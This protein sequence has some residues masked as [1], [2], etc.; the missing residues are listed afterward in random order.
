MYEVGG[1]KLQ[2]QVDLSGHAR[3]RRSPLSRTPSIFKLS[4]SLVYREPKFVHNLDEFM[5]RVVYTPYNWQ[6]GKL[7]IKLPRNSAC[8]IKRCSYNHFSYM[9]SKPLGILCRP[10]IY[11]RESP[12][13]TLNIPI[14]IGHS[15]FVEPRLI[16]SHPNSLV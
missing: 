8:S 9:S 5:C 2:F 7:A 14:S 1:L 12:V 10:L 13:P 15:N 4:T 3:V 11:S 16:S 6:V